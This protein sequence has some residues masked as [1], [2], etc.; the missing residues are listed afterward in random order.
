MSP[1][2]SSGVVSQRTRITASPALPRSSAVSASS[3]IAPVAAPGDAFEPLRGD[4]D[5]GVRVDHRVQELV[6]LPGIDARDRLLARDEALVDHLGRDSK[7]SRR[8]ALPGTG[9]EE[10]ERPLLHR[11]LDVLQVAV[12]ALE[13]VERVD[14]AARTRSACARA[15]RSIGSGVRMPATTSSPCAFK[16]NSP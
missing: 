9:L 10:V 15:S 14:A 7:R 11:E 6:E 1:W 5:P 3:T 4:V 12:V 2:M 16:R 13:A 8:R